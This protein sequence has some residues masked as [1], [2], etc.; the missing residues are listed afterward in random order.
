[1]YGYVY[2]TTNLI[3]NKIYVGKHKGEFDKNYYGSGKIITNSLKKYSKSNH[4][5]DILE[6]ANDKNQLDDLEKY[7]IKFYKNIYGCKCMNI[8][9]GGEGGNVWEYADEEKYISFCNKMKDI[10]SKRCN[11][12][13]FKNKCSINMTNR[14]KNSDEREKQ[15]KRIKNAWSSEELKTKQSK[16]IKACYK[17]KKRDCS[18]NNTP[19]MIALNNKKLYFNSRKELDEFLS[20]NYNGFNIPRGKKA[21]IALDGSKA[22]FTKNK[23]YEKLNGMKIYKNYKNIEDV[24]TNE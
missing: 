23:K 1:M 11:T 9:N 14:Y 17:N 4:K 7:Y 22:F 20:K 3:T 12:D 16:I 24:E 18:L 8:A 21:N 10:N 2:I 5:V 15:S 19:Y 6:Y 13:E